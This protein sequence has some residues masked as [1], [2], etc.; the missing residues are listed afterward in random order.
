MGTAKSFNIIP[1]LMIENMGKDK[2]R[3]V[4]IHDVNFDKDY[5][6]WID[7]LKSRYRAHR[8]RLQLK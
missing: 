1:K 4:K 7:E 6:N 8:S 5:V 3:V 2:P